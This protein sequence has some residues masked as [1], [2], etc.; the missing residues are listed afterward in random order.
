MFA[1]LCKKISLPAGVSISCIAWN[2]SDKLF[3]VGGDNGFLKIL[4]LDSTAKTGLSFNHSLTGHTQKISHVCWNESHSRLTTA[5]TS[6]SIIVWRF[7]ETESTENPQDITLHFIEEMVNHRPKHTIIDIQWTLDGERVVVGY[8]DGHALVGT[9]DGNRVWGDQILA[10]G[11]KLTSLKWY[12]D[13]KLIALSSSNNEPDIKVFDSDGTFCSSLLHLFPSTKASLL[14]DPNVLPSSAQCYSN[15][16]GV[17]GS[18]AFLSTSHLFIL[19]LNKN[20]YDYHFNSIVKPSSDLSSVISLNTS[21]SLLSFTSSPLCQW[22]PDG[23]VLAVISENFI[24]FY[25]ISG[26]FLYSIP[27][28][29][30]KSQSSPCCLTWCYGGSMMAIAQGNQVV[31]LNTRFTNTIHSFSENCLSL[32]RPFGTVLALDCGSTDTGNESCAVFLNLTTMDSKILSLSGYLNSCSSSKY[33][34]AVLGDMDSNN[35]SNHLPGLDE[36]LMEVQSKVKKG[37]D[38]SLSFFLTLFDSVGAQLAQTS[39]ILKPLLLCCNDSMAIVS[40]SRNLCIWRFPLS[41]NPNDDQKG[42]EVSYILMDDPSYSLI[43]QTKFSSLSNSKSTDS[44]N[45]IFCNNF[46]LF[47]IFKS[48]RLLLFSLPDISFVQSITLSKMIDL[49]ESTVVKIVINSDS[50]KLIMITS[51]AVLHAFSITSTNSK[52]LNLELI[53]QLTR[54][55]C[56]R[57]LFAQDDPSLM[58]FAEKGKLFTVRSDKLEEPLSTAQ[59]CFPTVYKDLNITCLSLDYLLDTLVPSHSGVKF[60][61]TSKALRDLE[62][63]AESVPLKDSFMYVKEN[64]HPRLWLK[65]AQVALNNSDFD[66]AFKCFV[67]TSDYSGIQLIKKLRTIRDPKLRAAEVALFFGNGEEAEKIY[68]SLGRKDLASTLCRQLG[69]L[70]R[71]LE[72][73]GDDTMLRKD[74]LSTLGYKYFDRGELGSAA[75]IFD[76]LNDFEALSLCHF[77]SENFVGL[78]EIAHRLPDKHPLLPTIC[79]Y[80]TAGGFAVGAAETAVKA[81]MLERAVDICFEYNEWEK[82]VQLANEHNI[83]NIVEKLDKITHLTIESGDVIGGISLFLKGQRFAKAARILVDLGKKLIH[84]RLKVNTTNTKSVSTLFDN[85]KLN[86]ATFLL[87]KKLFCFA[88]IQLNQERSLKLNSQNAGKGTLNNFLNFESNLSKDLIDCWRNPMAVH[89]LLLVER[90]LYSGE[91]NLAL[92]TATI[93]FSYQDVIPKVHCVSLLIL[94]ALYA[95]KLDCVSNALTCIESDESIPMSIRKS[96]IN[97]GFILFKDREP[98]PSEPPFPPTQCLHCREDVSCLEPYCHCGYALPFCIASGQRLSMNDVMWRCSRCSQRALKACMEGAAVCP[99]CHE[100]IVEEE[101]FNLEIEEDSFDD[102]L[103]EFL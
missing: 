102:E 5:D 96:F 15:L 87:I 75:E 80:L 8:S 85:L 27:I 78:L 90:H 13:D 45:F 86:S 69:D 54:R 59:P 1:S 61:L 50:S 98:S 82:V 55:D 57:A 22:S 100:E 53:P 74:A 63:M 14:A 56:W 9:V 89:L 6:G 23:M 12:G 17:T 49:S 47:V 95:E 20:G 24:N 79:D 3:A 73:S 65:V 68:L 7:V 71:A 25:S 46:Y 93:L 42:L 40:D 21:S 2:N 84:E 39:T 35:D 76:E 67:E 44:V 101:D 51:Q 64:P 91:Y 43:E 36:Q 37:Q 66:I 26:D 34:V 10:D 60:Q 97:F 72:L 11:S 33:F 48:G 16:A 99:L 70:H 38:R 4:K 92:V 52:Q 94:A 77:E 58:V 32:I 81:G 88:A 28:P 103:E 29:K 19:P 41:N 18:L 83:P 31:F 62:L 30:P